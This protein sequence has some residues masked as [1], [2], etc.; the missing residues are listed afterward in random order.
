M[1]AL[2]ARVGASGAPV[3]PII[4]ARSRC[5]TNPS[6]LFC[7]SWV[8]DNWTGVL[9]PKLLQHIEMTVT[10]VAIGFVLAFAAALAA[11]R[12]SWFDRLFTGFSTL[13][14]TIPSLALFELLVPLTGLTLLT[15]EIGLVGY[16][17]LALFANILA[18]LRETP[19]EV[20]GAARGMGMTETQILLRVRMPVAVPTIMAGLR[21]ATVITISLATIAAY[22][23]PDGL[24]QPILDGISTGF[25]TELI[26][27]GGL[28]I[29]LAL[30][31]DALLVGLQRLLT[32]WRRARVD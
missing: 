8:A 30:F 4:H 18:G 20:V 7:P 3:I 10:A 26:A 13:L 6:S 19:P 2:A 22:I 15:I 21:I 25:N 24:G 29:L 14:Y 31:A 27:A 23:T 11:Q 17:L 12:V 28:A 5:V 16:T 9:E 1:T 32:P